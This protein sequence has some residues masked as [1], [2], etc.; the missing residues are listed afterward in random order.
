MVCKRAYVYEREKYM[1]ALLCH[2]SVYICGLAHLSLKF[3]GRSKYQK[4]NWSESSQI[5]QDGI[6][7]FVYIIRYTPAEMQSCAS[8]FHCRAII[9]VDLLD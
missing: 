4:T 6:A 9:K 3:P 8:T 1:I 5:D 7:L 2:V